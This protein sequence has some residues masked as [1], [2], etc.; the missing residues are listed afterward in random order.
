[1]FWQVAPGF[2]SA[3]G[4]VLVLLGALILCQIAIVGT[5]AVTMAS[6][7]LGASVLWSLACE[8]LRLWP[9]IG[10][11]RLPDIA[12]AFDRGP[13]LAVLLA[14]FA[15]HA[16][17]RFVRGRPVLPGA[18][19]KRSSTSVHGQADWLDPARTRDLLG[20]GEIVLGEAY[21]VDRSKV[22][23]TRFDPSDKTTW[24]EGGQHP[25][26]RTDGLLDSGHVLACIGSGGGK[27]ASLVIP[28]AAGW[29]SGLVVLDI[30]GEVH[31]RVAALRSGNGRRVV[32]LRPGDPAS[33]SFNALAWIDRTS[34]R[35]LIDIR[36]VVAW[37]MGETPS[38]KAS[39][40]Q[41]FR[42]TSAA[43]IAAIVA[44]IVFDPDLDDEKRTL[45]SVRQFLTLPRPVLLKHLDNIH[46]KGPDYGFG[47]PAQIAG[48]LKGITEKQFDGFY[49]QA[50]TATAWLSIPSLAALVS[51]G[52]PTTFRTSELRTGNL[53][54]FL[55]I[56]LGTL[57]DFPELARLVIGSLLNELYLAKG[58]LAGRT[59]FLIDEAARL[60]YMRMLEEARDA[61]RGFK[62]NLMLMFQTLGQM[63]VYGRSG[64]RQWMD[65]AAIKV[66][67]SIGDP[68]SAETISRQCG[69]FTALAS[70]TSTGTGT[71][72]RKDE[73]FGSSSRNSGSSTSEVARRL[74]RPEEVLTLRGDEQLILVKG[75]P[76]IRCGKAFWF[77]RPELKAALA[78]SSFEGGRA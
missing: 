72:H 25:L 21:R 50:G 43:L 41:Y 64:V 48:N 47:F 36:R 56:D 38:E 52:T 63:D 8:L 77:R 3:V 66:F 42:D 34:D 29:P 16:A 76:P 5:L 75:Q 19:I 78:S 65:V 13:V 54:V 1:M 37:L 15:M 4:P 51:A 67:S 58:Q 59:L 6:L 17:H 20:R 33:A 14:T 24:G 71:S 12:F 60:G 31:D 11:S 7:V 62:I 39:T 46:A 73:L 18:S 32:A 55:C 30:K 74:I 26:L 53:D 57:N 28:T 40:N 35:A 22:A 9:Y 68:D 27:T 45:T 69:E 49:G 2:G 10:V 23:K 44:D 61:G 70:G